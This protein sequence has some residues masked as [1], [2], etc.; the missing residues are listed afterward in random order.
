MYAEFAPVVGTL[1]RELPCERPDAKAL[2]PKPQALS[3]KP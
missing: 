3:P 1:C 2:N